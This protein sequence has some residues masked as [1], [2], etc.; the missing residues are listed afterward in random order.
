MDR[1]RL[2]DE[3]LILLP[4]LGRELGR[5]VPLEMEE[6]L[7]GEIS[8]R[9]LP[10]GVQVSPGHIQVLIA[11]ARGPRSV[12]QIADSLGVSRPAATQL[13]DRLEEHGMVHRR[14]DPADRRVHLVD[15]VPGMHEVAR[16]IMGV[17]RRQLNAALDGLNDKEALAFLKGLKAITEALGEMPG[18]E[19]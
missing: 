13:V 18:E 7:R 6:E 19:N 4:A 11:L 10:V 16:K 3:V 12:G 1:E 14:P 17:R 5:P 2:V 8:R 15:Y 9:G